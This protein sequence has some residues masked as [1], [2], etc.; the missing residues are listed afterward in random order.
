M[1]YRSWD[2]RFYGYGLFSVLF[3]LFMISLFIDYLLRPVYM[4]INQ[5]MVGSLWI[6][7][8]A[9]VLH[10][11]CLGISTY[12]KGKNEMKSAKF[13]HDHYWFSRAVKYTFIG[14]VWIQSL[15]ALIYLLF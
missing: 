1:R 13:F 6:P 3:I 15:R 14:A 11:I 7:F 8:G 5:V 2:T 4:I 10:K 9:Y 12:Y